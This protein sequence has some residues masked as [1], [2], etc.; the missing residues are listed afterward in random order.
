MQT[1]AEARKRTPLP[2][3]LHEIEWALAHVLASF[4]VHSGVLVQKSISA[5]FPHKTQK[6]VP[7]SVIFLVKKDSLF[8]PLCKTSK[9][10][11]MGVFR[12][13]INAICDLSLIFNYD[14][15]AN[16][17]YCIIIHNIFFACPRCS[18]LTVFVL[19]FDVVI[20][21]GFIN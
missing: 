14:Q 1:E 21:Q 15:T 7:I 10:S 3:L 6:R 20:R 13:V 8:G 11:D 9:C 12:A 18:N 16:G 17:T 5:F 4:S 2:Q 19:L